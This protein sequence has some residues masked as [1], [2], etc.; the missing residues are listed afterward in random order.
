[1]RHDVEALADRCTVLL[2]E[3]ELRL[4][5]LERHAPESALP[6]KGGCLREELPC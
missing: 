5:K 1:V 6:S 3:H 2:G 4:D